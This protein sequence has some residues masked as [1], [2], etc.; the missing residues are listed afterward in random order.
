MKL[1]VSRRTRPSRRSKPLP[2]A[3]RARVFAL[4]AIIVVGCAALGL[5]VTSLGARLLGFT[6]H[7]SFFTIEN[8]QVVGASPTVEQE[9]LALI[10]AIQNEQSSSLFALLSDRTRESVE[11]LPRVRSARVRKDFPQTLRIEIEERVPLVVGLA[12]ELFWMDREGVLLARATAEEIT[13]ARTPLLTGLRGAGSTPGTRIDQPRLSEMLGALHAL[14]E[15]DI[16]MWERFAEWHLNSRNEIVGVMREGLEVRFGDHD[17]MEKMPILAAVLR[18]K[19]DLENK[20]LID[21]RF[22]SQVVYY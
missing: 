18:Q 15:R 17:P 21:L 20:T 16:V 2:F 7:S 6:L 8:V 13:E 3:E 10:A 22:K 1:P 14:K 19:G 5:A 12:G 11:Q 4:R 9:V